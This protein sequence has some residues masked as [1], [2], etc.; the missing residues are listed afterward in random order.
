MVS[1]TSSS[2]FFAA[3][4]LQERQHPRSL[5]PSSRPP[6]VPPSDQST[7]NSSHH[8]PFDDRDNMSSDSDPEPRG[9]ASIGGLESVIVRNTPM[10]PDMVGRPSR[11]H[12]HRDHDALNARLTVWDGIANKQLPP[13]ETDMMIRLLEKRADKRIVQTWIEGQ[14]SPDLHEAAITDRK[15]V[16]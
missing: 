2:L 13:E 8:N 3:Y 1:G 4:N 6:P 16:V 5:L 12:Q 7:A 10:S 9:P 15:S 11:S 14:P